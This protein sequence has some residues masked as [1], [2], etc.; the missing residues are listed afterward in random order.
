MTQLTIDLETVPTTQ[1]W[2][3]DQIR[4]SIKPPGNIKKQESIDKWFEENADQAALEKI[5]KTAFN[6]SVGEILMIGYAIDN[7]P[8]NV[9]RRTLEDPEEGILNDFV[10][11]LEST[12][13][14][15]WVGHNI[16]GF[17]LRF[18]WQRMKINNVKCNVA[19]PYNAK[20]WES[21]KVF[22]TYT[23]WAGLKSDGYNDLDTLCRV[24][25]INLPKGMH[26][27]EVYD[28][29]L[30]GRYDDIA[31]YCKDDVERARQLYKRITW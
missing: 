30:D 26:G 7:N 28:A 10:D 4:Q 8:V 25:G 19:I 3:I 11:V 5:R 12:R 23:Q 1:G 9:L 17:D 16:T 6:G 13:N 29:A 14:L 22:D 27:S 18:L 15:T 31:N 20:P 21:D 24:F 2:L